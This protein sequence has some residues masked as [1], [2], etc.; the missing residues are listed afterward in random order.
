MTTKNN[1][2]WR[3]YESHQKQ[4]MEDFLKYSRSETEIREIIGY[5]IQHRELIRDAQIQELEDESEKLLEKLKSVKRKKLLEEIEC[6][7]EVLALQK[8][9]VERGEES[10]EEE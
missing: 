1:D 6:F 2:F 10:K 4:A 3:S 9:L 8:N 5:L 7:K